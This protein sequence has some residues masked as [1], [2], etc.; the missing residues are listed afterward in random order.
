V[1]AEKRPTGS[2]SSLQG[3]YTPAQPYK[4]SLQIPV[5]FE[6]GC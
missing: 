4:V 1:I 2:L 3:R 6:K 5:N